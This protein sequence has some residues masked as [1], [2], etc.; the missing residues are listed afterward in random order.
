VLWIAA[1]WQDHAQ[2]GETEGA[3]RGYERFERLD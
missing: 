1:S 3:M 2:V